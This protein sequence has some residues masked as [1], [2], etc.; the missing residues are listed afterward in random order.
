MEHVQTKEIQ[1]IK[2]DLVLCATGR[3]PLT[4]NMGLE[5]VGVQTDRF[6]RVI[7]NQRL[8]SSVPNI[9][10]VGD[11]TDKVPA[12]A[13]KAEDEALALVDQLIGK[14]THLNYGNIPSVLYTHPE[15]AC[16]GL[17]EEQLKA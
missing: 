7:V 5:A 9:Y 10:A 4:K 12:M 14:N 8:Q 17:T 11:V 1:K 13:H 15:V 16:V 3:Y 6:G 2:G